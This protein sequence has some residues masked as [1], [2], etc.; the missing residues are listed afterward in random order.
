[1]LQYAAVRC[2]MLQFNQREMIYI[3][4]CCRVLPCVAVCCSVLQCVAVQSARG[5]LRIVID[6][7]IVQLLIHACQSPYTLTCIKRHTCVFHQ[8]P[9]L[10]MK[11]THM[12]KTLHVYICVH[13][14]RIMFHSYVP[15]PFCSHVLFF[16][17]H[18]H[19]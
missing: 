6:H 19:V 9:Y 14:H 4:V 1:M 18:S 8:R 5:E 2:S 13:S 3:T 12:Y 10:S 15:H 11:H 17:S 7:I 16:I